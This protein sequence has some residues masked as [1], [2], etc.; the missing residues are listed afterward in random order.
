MGIAGEGAAVAR[1][2]PLRPPAGGKPPPGIAGVA[3]DIAALLRAAVAWALVVQDARPR[4]AAAR[5]S[6]LPAAQRPTPCEPT[7]PFP[8]VLGPSE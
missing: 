2:P 6:Q 4:K 3:P 5:L 7:V 8:A 1:I